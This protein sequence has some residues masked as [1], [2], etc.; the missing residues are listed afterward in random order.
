MQ[1][2]NIIY[3]IYSA[4]LYNLRHISFLSLGFKI[5]QNELLARATSRIQFFYIYF[6]SYCIFAMIWSFLSFKLNR[7]M[8]ELAKT[9]TEFTQMYDLPNTSKGKC[10][11]L[12]VRSWLR[13]V[14]RPLVMI[15]SWIN[16]FTYIQVNE[17]HG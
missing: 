4:I 7:S 11:S 16:C 13:M 15:K 8:E 3:L 10:V 17:V 1:R 12:T 14:Q 2:M 5:F 9:V 6:L